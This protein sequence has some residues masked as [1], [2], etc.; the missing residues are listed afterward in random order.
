MLIAPGFAYTGE[1]WEFALEALV[2]ATRA[3]GTGVGVT[4]QLH[5]A[6]DFLFSDSIGKPLFPSS[7]AP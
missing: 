5:F 3:T 2:P 1:G 7:L 6:L 4:A